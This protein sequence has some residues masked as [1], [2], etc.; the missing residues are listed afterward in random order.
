ME[1]FGALAA[2]YS[3]SSRCDSG[4]LFIVKYIKYYT[5]YLVIYHNW[6]I[7][8]A[9]DGMAITRSSNFGTYYICFL[10]LMFS[11]NYILIRHFRF[12]H[13]LTNQDAEFRK[14][15]EKLRIGFL[16]KTMILYQS[17]RTWQ[18]TKLPSQSAP[19]I[20]V[21]KTWVSLWRGKKDPDPKKYQ[22]D[23]IF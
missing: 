20:L 8:V 15:A 18:A 9:E 10:G 23:L 1:S 4:V 12:V 5:Y 19:T 6:I 21:L 7:Q 14:W 11:Q 16:K 13:L 17:L 22:A 3:C 2:W